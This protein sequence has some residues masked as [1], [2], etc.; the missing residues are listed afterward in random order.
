MGY[1]TVVFP[2][3]GGEA[4]A[5]GAVIEHEGSGV[6]LTAGAATASVGNFVVDTGAAEVRGDLLGVT[7]GSP[8]A[9]FNFGS[10]TVL[11]GVELTISSTLAGALSEVFGAPDLTDAT[12][13]YAVP[14]PQVAP[15][16]LPAGALLL[17]GGL[18]MFGL[19]RRK[20]AA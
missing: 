7:T 16:P 11:P 17:I 1:P 20:R 3:T 13:G 14:S 2:V 10:G 19:V 18:G 5:G 4:G 6:S 15:V 8:L 12:F 9:F